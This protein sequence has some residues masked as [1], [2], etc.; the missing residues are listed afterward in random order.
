MTEAEGQVLVQEA[1]ARVRERFDHVLILAS[2][3]E[4]GVSEMVADGAG[5]WYA[6]TGMAKDFLDRDQARLVVE[7]QELAAEADVFLEEAD[8][9]EE[10]DDEEARGF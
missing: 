4:D 8:E 6:Q 7:E 10:E 9:D 1:L 5:S 2:W 3:D